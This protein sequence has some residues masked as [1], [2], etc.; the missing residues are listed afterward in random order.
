[1][2]AHAGSGGGG[3][4]RDAG[5]CAHPARRAHRLES[6]VHRRGSD[7]RRQV[8][9]HLVLLQRELHKEVGEQLRLRARR[10]D[11]ARDL[12]EALEEDKGV[13]RRQLEVELRLRRL[14]RRLGGPIFLKASSPE[15]E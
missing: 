4:M 9:E 1:M 2:W 8:L 10:G 5:G 3:A 15:A 14:A 6:K 7:V 11:D 13:R 12:G